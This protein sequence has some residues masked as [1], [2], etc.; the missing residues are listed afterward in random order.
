[1]LEFC[2]GFQAETGIGAIWLSVIS[3][4]TQSTMPSLLKV[5]CTCSSV[6]KRRREL[7][8]PTGVPTEFVTDYFHLTEDVEVVEVKVYE[9]LAE[10]RVGEK[11]GCFAAPLL[12]GRAEG[13]RRRATQMISA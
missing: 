10:F 1:M 7:S 8:G 2:C 11:R 5:G 9:T 4:I 12:P 6:D 13:L 3:T